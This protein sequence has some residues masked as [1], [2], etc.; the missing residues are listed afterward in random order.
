MQAMKA[1]L[2]FSAA[3]RARFGRYI[4]YIAIASFLI[5]LLLY[6]SATYLFNW[7]PSGLLT[8]PINAIYTPF[9]FLLVYEAYLLLYYLQQS[10]TF[11]I[12]KQYEIITL[13]LIRG[14]FKDITHLHFINGSLE[15]RN[16][17]ELWYDLI[18]VLVV[19]L[20]IFLF[21]RVSARVKIQAGSTDAPPQMKR[22]IQ[23]KKYLAVSLL[24]ISVMLGGYSFID[25][26]LHFSADQTMQATVDINA[27]FFDHFFTLLIMSDVIILLFSLFYT[28][29]FPLIIRNSSFV[30]STILLKLSFAATG[31]MEQVFIIVGVSF[32]VA[33]YAI[34]NLY[35][36]GKWQASL[37][38][39]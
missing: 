18:T 15:L 10:T 21:Y 26:I 20:L 30:V 38:A 24:V 5:H 29:D 12:G 16:H 39:E 22:F 9:S 14:I 7:H 37:K 23:A 33:M 35:T 13:I 28:D 11:Y 32:G 6:F 4:L 27:I 34:A 1:D 36:Q 3:F 31:I 8:N 17:T 25:W 2:F 19:F